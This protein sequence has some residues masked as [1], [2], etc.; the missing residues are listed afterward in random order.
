MTTLSTL[1]SLS[2][3]RWCDDAVDISLALARWCAVVIIHLAFASES[4]DAV[5]VI[6]AYLNKLVTRRCQH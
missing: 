4:D 6:L 5:G 3:A 2:F 1:F